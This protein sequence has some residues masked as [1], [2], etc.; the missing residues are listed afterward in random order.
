MPN[1][2]VIYWNVENFG[3]GHDGRRG[4]YVPLCNFIAQVVRNVDADM[5][6]LMEL[7]ST[8]LMAR[9]VQL[10]QSL[11]N[12]YN[13]GGI[14]TCDWYCDYVPGALIHDKNGPPYSPNRVGFTDLARHEGYAVFWKQNIDKFIMQR[15]DPIITANATPPGLPVGGTVP[16]TQSGGVIV[17]DAAA[18]LN[19]LPGDVVIPAVTPQYTL[20]AGSNVAAGGITRAGVIVV[21]AGVT[22]APT[23]LHA[24]DI[25]SVGTIIAFAGVTLNTPVLGVH[26]IV[27]PGTYTLTTNLTLPPALEVILPQHVL[28]LVLSSRQLIGG[29][30]ANYNPMGANHWELGSFTGTNG[31]NF[32]TGCRRPAFCTIKTNTALP[33]AQQLIPIIFYHAPVAAPAQAMLSCAIAQPLYEAMATG[34]PAYVHNGRAVVGGDFNARL[35]RAAAHYRIYTDDYVFGGAG[36]NDAGAHNIRVKQLAPGFVPNFPPAALPLT[37]ADN[38]QNKSSVQL[39]HPVRPVMG[40]NHPVLSN[41]IDHYRRSAIDNIFYRGFTPAQAPRYLFRATLPGGVQQQFAA[42]LY[43]LVRAVSRTIPNP[44]IAAAAPMGAPADNFF[45]PPAIITAFNGLPVFAPLAMLAAAPVGLNSVLNPVQLLADINAGVFQ[46]PA[47]G[48]PPAGAGPYA[49]E[50][51]LPVVIT[52]ARRAAEFIKLFVSDHLPV[53]FEMVI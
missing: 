6:C 38:P 17:R 1:I 37:G 19:F 39:R 23:P 32:W 30:A 35:D 29:M 4:N 8:A 7:K 5:L 11:A 26:P 36:C 24:G 12:A 13:I 22:A 52:P 42:D 9:L 41:N 15:A 2:K 10:Q 27:I 44:P 28:S 50:A 53:I 31:A 14:Q 20:P 33:V 48:N 3:D 47:A 46:T 49:G 25:I 43:D 34:A 51:A 18:G 45:I 40:V 21:P 16:N